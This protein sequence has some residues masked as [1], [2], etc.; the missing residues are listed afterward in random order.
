M[1]WDIGDVTPEAEAAPAEVSWDIGTAGA[2][3]DQGGEP[4]MSWDIGDV[5]NE[6]ERTA[7]PLPTPPFS[8]SWKDF[9]PIRPLPS[10]LTTFALS[11]FVSLSLMTC[12]SLSL[13]V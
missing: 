11:S 10:Q 5:T 9:H 2:G 3:A 7:S 4:D 13:C 1:S 8:L 6:G 12:F